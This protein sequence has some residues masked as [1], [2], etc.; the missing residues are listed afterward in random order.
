[1]ELVTA[2]DGGEVVVYECPECGY[3]EEAR[4]PPREDEF[5]E[6]QPLDPSTLLD[7]EED[8]E[9]AEDEPE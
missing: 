9:P 5:E 8:E 4:I 3:Q 1:M 7:D 2:D 6:I